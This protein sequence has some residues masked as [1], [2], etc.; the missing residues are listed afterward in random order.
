MTLQVDILAFSAEYGA[1]SLVDVRKP[2]KSYENI[3]LS[4]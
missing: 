1:K 4:E 3:R 2:K